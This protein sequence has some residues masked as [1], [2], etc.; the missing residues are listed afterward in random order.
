[1]MEWP[2]TQTNSSAVRIIS[3]PASVSAL[4]VS[5]FPPSSAPPTFRPLDFPF[6]RSEIFRANLNE[7][8]SFFFA[9]DRNELAFSVVRSSLSKYSCDCFDGLQ[10]DGR[11]SSLFLRFS[12]WELLFNVVSSKFVQRWRRLYSIWIVFFDQVSKRDCFLIVSMD[13][14]LVA[15]YCRI[16]HVVLYCIIFVLYS[17]HYM[18]LGG[19]LSSLFL[20]FS[21]WELLL[22]VVSLRFV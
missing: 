14:S 20:R 9:R 22:N 10:P 1:M 5:P 18:Q 12:R 4:L 3:L 8:V 16:F 17:E 19:R 2:A 21:C 15:D 11:L 13:C 6:P 7:V